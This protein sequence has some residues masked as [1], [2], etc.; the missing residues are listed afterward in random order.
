MFRFLTVLF[1]LLVAS[2]LA[3]QSS[4]KEGEHE[5]AEARRE[6]RV[7]ARG[8]TNHGWFGVSLVLSAAS[9]PFGAAVVPAIAL[10]IR[11]AVPAD[12][13]FDMRGSASVYAQNFSAGYRASA[14]QEQVTRAVLGS[15]V[16]VGLFYVIRSMFDGAQAGGGRVRDPSGPQL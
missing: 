13:L 15:A 8:T 6:G 3:A 2:P 4:V 5:A 14:R 9:G 12:S 16:G 1:L 7:A 10:A 11:P